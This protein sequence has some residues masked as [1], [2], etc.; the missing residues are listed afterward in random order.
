SI[1]AS[2]C[3]TKMQRESA[4]FS[5]KESELHFYRT[6]MQ[7]ESA[8]LPTKNLYFFFVLQKCIPRALFF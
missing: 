2:F 3:R 1:C 5:N 6:E 4:N 8:I 7:R